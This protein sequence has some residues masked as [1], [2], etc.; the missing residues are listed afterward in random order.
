MREGRAALHWQWL[1]SLFFVY[2][3]AC[4]SKPTTMQSR[5]SVRGI[6]QDSAGQPVPNAAVMITGGSHE[7][8]DI[9]SITNDS[10]EF[11]L[12]NVVVPGTYTLQIE[13]NNKS[14]NTQVNLSGSDT[15]RIRF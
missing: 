2:A 3:A 10:G 5:L 11:Y 8:T 12:S 4:N 6:L 15:I 1:L 14:K 7:F 13:A 9:A